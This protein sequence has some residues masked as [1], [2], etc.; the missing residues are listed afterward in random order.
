VEHFDPQGYG[1]PVADLLADATPNSL[2]P[3]MPNAD[4]QESLQRMD[5]RRLLD[6]R[7]C[8]DREMARCCIAGLW[9]LHDYLEE[10]HRISQG[11]STPTGSYWH[12]IM[13][14]REPDYSNS[15]YWFRGV[16][17]HPIFPELAREAQRLAAQHGTDTASAFLASGASW[18][19]FGFV[20][21][22]AAAARGPEMV[23]HLCRQIAQAEWR[24][25]F[26]HCYRHAT[27]E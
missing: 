17:R 22:C 12:G 8:A 23:E 13:H 6:G 25:L 21:V 3:G 18:D 4:Q 26:D 15:K 19:P 10:S 7:P 1:Q 20:D 9:L 16:G 2:G 5:V 27:G 24:L 14:R 11:I